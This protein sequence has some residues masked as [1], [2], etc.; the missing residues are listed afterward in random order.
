MPHF[1]FSRNLNHDHYEKLW[2][3]E[4]IERVEVVLKESLDVRGRVQSH[5]N[6]RFHYI[7]SGGWLDWIYYLSIRNLYCFHIFSINKNICLPLPGFGISEYK[8]QN[9]Q[10]WTK[11]WQLI[12]IKEN[13][14]STNFC[15]QIM[16]CRNFKYVSLIPFQRECIST[17]VLELWETCCKTMPLNWQ[18]WWEW[19]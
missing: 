4:H 12:N 17:M 18:P 1:P 3:R 10:K 16:R 6:P 15:L 7:L 14:W 19:N 5:R 11:L 2:N 9:L 8:S 13:Y